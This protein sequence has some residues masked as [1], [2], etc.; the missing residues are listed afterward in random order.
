MISDSPQKIK[1][2][3][4]SILVTLCGMAWIVGVTAVIQGY[5]F[6]SA[7]FPDPGFRAAGISAPMMYFGAALVQAAVLLLPLLPLG[8]LWRA[9][10]LSLAVCAPGSSQPSF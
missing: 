3:W 6:I 4:V 8:L 10:A 7:S 9:P 1:S 2:D 5:V